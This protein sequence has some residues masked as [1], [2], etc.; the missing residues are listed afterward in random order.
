MLFFTFTNE[1][2]S[3]GVASKIYE[4]CNA[5]SRFG[6]ET[7]LC[8][9][10]LQKGLKIFK[11]KNNKLEN[12]YFKTGHKYYNYFQGYQFYI[13][14]FVISNNINIIY[15]RRLMPLIPNYLLFFFIFRF[16]GVKLIYEIPTYPYIK[17]HIRTRDYKHITLELLFGKLPF[18]LYNWVLIITD[19]K[20]YQKT[21]KLF[22][23]KVKRIFNGYVFNNSNVPINNWKNIIKNKFDANEIRIIGVGH[24]AFWHGYDKIIKLLKINKSR[25]K[26]KFYIIGDGKEIEKLKHLASDLPHNSEVIFID[27]MPKND[28][29]NFYNLCHIGI[30]SIGIKRINLDEM[31]VLKNKEYLDNYLPL[32]IDG[33]DSE[34]LPEFSFVLY[35]NNNLED[36]IS[37]YEKF[38]SDP[39]LEIMNELMKKMNW[40]TYF[41]NLI[42]EIK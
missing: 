36:I 28:L 19:T 21:R 41:S 12:I 15:I 30:G 17:Q 7:Y 25:Y 18:I 33:F 29:K 27:R 32:I 38:Y 40:E 39:Q 34:F 10:D 4:Q 11:I 9:C 26:I 13:L 16:W 22:G 37:F 23:N 31:S 24:I 14:K 20:N 5:F 8:T 3:L 1:K 2:G 35:Y 6:F 42:K